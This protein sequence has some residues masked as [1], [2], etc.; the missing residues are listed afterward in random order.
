MGY[1]I[2]GVVIA[3]LINAIQLFIIII[4]GFSQRTKN[5]KKVGGYYNITEGQITK[6]KP[7]T[8]KVIFYLF[9]ALCITPILSW[10]YIFRWFFALIRARINKAPLPEKLKEINYKLS[11]IDLPKEIVKDCLNEIARFYTGQDA[12]FRNPYDDEYYKDSYE[13]ISGSGPND[14]NTDLELNKSGHTFIINARDPDFGEHID[15]FEYKF[16][17]TVLWSRVIESKHKYPTSVEY[18]IRDGVVL[19]QE[20]REQHKNGLFSSEEDINKSLKK[21][22]AE[23]EWS[24]YYNSAIRYFILFRHGDV[25]DD[26]AAKKFFRSELERITNG[27]KRLDERIQTLGFYIGKHRYSMGNTILRKDETTSEDN[28]GEISEILHENSMARY[29]IAYPEFANYERIVE[30]LNLYISKL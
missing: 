7:S 20:Y 21:L 30:D 8:G 14:W 29:G 2:L 18:E 22:Y 24:E 27:Y 23:I 11:S 1:Y 25:L 26:I 17:G 4:A 19:E 9:A 16:E 5:I 28:C 12:D 15:T 3:F 13:I 6:E 10:F